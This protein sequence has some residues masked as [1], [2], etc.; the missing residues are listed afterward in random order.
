MASSG[1]LQIHLPF[2]EIHFPCGFW[3][4][5][6]FGST[7]LQIR[8]LF[9]FAGRSVGWIAG[10]IRM[11][12]LLEFGRRA[13]FYVRVLSGYEER[14]IRS[15]RL[16]LEKRLKQVLGLDLL[17]LF[18]SFSWLIMQ[19]LLLG[20]ALHLGLLIGECDFLSHFAL[21]N[22]ILYLYVKNFVFKWLGERRAREELN[23]G[24]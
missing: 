3:I 5:L 19:F 10:G 12:K 11:D 24:S 14:R 18:C 2:F 20:L 9:D 22:E 1:I 13:L 15:F 8:F 17:A 7:E 6:R 21:G 16:E 4:F 23:W